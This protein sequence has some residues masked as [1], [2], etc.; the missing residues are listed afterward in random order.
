MKEHLIENPYKFMTNFG[1]KDGHFYTL[2]KFTG[3]VID[4]RNLYIEKRK[5]YFFEFTKEGIGYN[6]DDNSIYINNAYTMDSKSHHIEN[7]K[8]S[9]DSN[10]YTRRK[11]KDI[12]N[13]WFEEISEEDFLNL[14]NGKPRTRKVFSIG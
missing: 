7:S 14:K 2:G 9:I 6:K 11:G 4:K 10:L 3:Q 1:L 8:V 13:Y 12:L 5:I